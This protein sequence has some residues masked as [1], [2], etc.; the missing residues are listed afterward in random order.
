MKLAWVSPY[1]VTESSG[2]WKGMHHNL[3][4]SLNQIVDIE[5]LPALPGGKDYFAMLVSRLFTI[6]TGYRLV[7]SHSDST[8]LRTAKSFRKLAQS[9][10]SGS[11]FFFGSSNYILCKPDRSYSCYL[12]SAFVLYLRFYEKHR[13]YLD[14][15]IRR[16]KRMEKQW[17][18]NCDNI[19][20]S[21]AFAREAIVDELGVDAKR[22]HV[23]FAGPNLQYVPEMLPGPKSNNIV[24]IAADFI[25]KGGERVVKAV[26]RAR[27]CIPTLRLHVIGQ[28]PPPELQK[29]FVIVHGWIDRETPHGKGTFDK[30]L[31]DCGLTV[32]LSKADLTPLA[33][34]ESFAYGVP[35]LAARAGG[36]PEMVHHGENGWLVDLKETEEGIAGLLVS[37]FSD[38]RSLANVSE[39]AR[40]TF[41]C[42]WNWGS[43][44]SRI[45]T[46]INKE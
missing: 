10:Q 39:Q 3:Y 20:T 25:R 1:S 43:V 27:E 19:F 38:P 45:S 9:C 26:E 24:F 42:D 33:I 21:S 12:D 16:L 18:Q 34:C 29:D 22:I 36:I 7:W 31:G 17:L 2:G 32:M 23:V 41:E 46:I 30:I 35:C 14:R 28:E 8:L 6:T 13:K 4:K 5:L 40:K 44:A 37:I 15:D 11:F